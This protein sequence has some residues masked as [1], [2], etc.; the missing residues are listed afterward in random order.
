MAIVFISPKEKQR[1]FLGGIITLLVLFLMGISLIVFLPEFISK[2]QTQVNPVEVPL[3]PS[4]MLNFNAIDSEEF[5]KLQPFDAMETLFAYVIEDKDSQQVSG[6][7]SAVSKQEAQKLLE[8]SGFKVL[9]L[10]EIGVGN[11]NP[12]TPY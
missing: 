12:F 3:N 7:I 6:N 8:S 2:N 4:L 10:Q 5:K 11:A 9:V 1:V